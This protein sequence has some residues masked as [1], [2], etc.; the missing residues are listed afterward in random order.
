MRLARLLILTVATLGAAGCIN[1]ASVI[2]VKPDGSGTLEHTMLVN[3][4]AVRGLMAGPAAAGAAQAK[5]A[6]T[7][8]NEADFK[9]SA[10]RMGVRPVSLTPTK[11]DNFE[12][13]KAIYAFDDI[14][15]IRIDQDPQ[16]SGS[17]TGR[18]SAAPAG[19]NPIRF[20]FVQQNGRSVLTIRVDE[21]AA[22]AATEKA[23]EAPDLG[24]ID[25]NMMKMI[26]SVFDGFR[27]QIDVEVDGQII[28]TNADYVN[29]SRVTLLEVD[30]SS[31]LADEAR[32]K[33][34]Q[35]KIRPGA[36]I[37]E[38]RPFLKDINGVK[39]NHPSL[40]IEFR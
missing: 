16:M 5:E 15:K 9:R 26:K 3:L 22:A 4:A 6:G 10:E 11:S 38:L 13:S 8:M 33:A 37:S 36:S 31:V 14:S 17:T 40:T 27:I 2:K 20:G 12:G 29:G 7:M 25:P 30:M 19:S 35:P 32:L 23:Q 1:S 39:V 28:K 34:L 18:F 21:K 24:S